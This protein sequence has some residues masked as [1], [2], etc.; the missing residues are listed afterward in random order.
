M[1]G[2][3]LLVRWLDV[4]NLQFV[5]SSLSKYVRPSFRANE[6]EVSGG[7]PYLCAGCQTVHI[8]EDPEVGARARTQPRAVWTHLNIWWSTTSETFTK[9]QTFLHFPRIVTV[10]EEFISYS[11]LI[12]AIRIPCHSACFHTAVRGTFFVLLSETLSCRT[13][14]YPDSRCKFIEGSKRLVAQ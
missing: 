1:S 8:Y 3:R 14:M 11:F 2:C 13:N 12:C 4:F 9:T 7:S 5:L 6:A 10:A